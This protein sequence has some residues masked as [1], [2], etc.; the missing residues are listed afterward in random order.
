METYSSPS[1]PDQKS[2]SP[3]SPLKNSP[4]SEEESDNTHSSP[5]KV[6]LDTPPSISEKSTGISGEPLVVAQYEDSSPLH[7]KEKELNSSVNFKEN[8]SSANRTGEAGQVTL[9]ALRSRCVP[10]TTGSGSSASATESPQPCRRTS[11]PTFLLSSSAVPLSPFQK[12]ILGVSRN[13]F[14]TFLK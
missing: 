13:H 11:S 8:G 3:C 14:E 9:L 4:S 5:V 2:S 10:L 12:K 1:G 7:G 6:S